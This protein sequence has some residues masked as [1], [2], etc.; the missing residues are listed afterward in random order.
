MKSKLSGSRFIFFLFLVTIILTA[1]AYAQLELV[2]ASHPVYDFLKRMQLENTIPRYN[3][4]LI[5]I[6]RG[7]IA[8]YLKTV[9]EKGKLSATDKKI[10]EDYFIEFEFELQKSTN[11]SSS[12]FGKFEG[13]SLFSNKKQKY[14]Y[15]FT[16]SNASLFVNLPV[17][18]SGYGSK[19]DFGDNELI[20]GDIGLSARGSMYGKVGYSAIY[21]GGKSLKGDDVAKLF[22]TD[23]NPV[24]KSN[25]KFFKD[26]YYDQFT[27]HIRY[28][29]KNNWLSLTAGRE[30]VLAGYGYIDRLFLSNNT[31]PMDFFRID[32]SYKKIKYNF[33]YGSIKGDSLGAD[34]KSKN[35]AFHRLNVQFSDVF[36][37][38]YYETVVISNNPFSFVYFNPISF[39]T[40]ADLNSGA[41]ETTE[42]NT[43]MGIDVEVNPVKNVALQGTLLVDDVNFSTLF[44]KDL[45]ANDNKFGYQLG[46]MWTKAFTL[47]DLSMKIEYTRLEPFVYS[48]R[49]N[50]DSYTHW[51]LS[52]GHALPSNSD[53]IALKFSYNISHRARLD[54]L[55]RFQRSADGIYYDSLNNRLINYGGNI[56]RGDGDKS[57]YYTFLL[58]DRTNRN[59]VSVNLIVEPIKQYFLEFRYRFLQNNLIYASKKEKELF[60][61]ALFRVML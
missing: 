54:F 51:D 16:D 27:G 42:N 36:K 61:Q 46:A 6:S 35:I 24:L 59:I 57:I 12:L 32:L 7:E 4:S 58:G 49:S 60:L 22:E 56:N 48:H 38:G 47:P 9:N 8:E 18:I 15:S 53:E 34:L 5:P 33:Y 37:I 10:L 1:N 52:L 29:T 30:P 14:V 45:T 17:S 26:N 11:K 3:S 31:V 41:K 19:G 39:I 28:Q 44:N 55:Y 20:L 50:K 40:S 13:E 25:P 21:N 43:L 23:Y 2:P